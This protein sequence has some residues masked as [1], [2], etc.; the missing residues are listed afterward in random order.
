VIQDQ[1]LFPARQPKRRRIA[2]DDR[3]VGCRGPIDHHL[4]LGQQKRLGAIGFLP[5]RGSLV[6]G[7]GMEPGRT[8]AGSDQSNR[9]YDGEQDGAG[10]ERQ[11]NDFMLGKAA[12]RIK[13]DLM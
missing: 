8:P 7:E 1:E 12:M 5:Q 9:G 4:R 2:L 6:A 10:C 11:K 13:R 3:L